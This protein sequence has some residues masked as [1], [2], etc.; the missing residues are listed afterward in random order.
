MAAERLEEGQLALL[1][2]AGHGLGGRIQDIGHLGGPQ[3]AG[4]VGCGLAAGLGCHGA[5]LRLPDSASVPGPIDRLLL[6]RR[7]R[8]PATQTVPGSP[9][10]MPD[11]QDDY[12]D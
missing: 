2:P 3:V 12:Q 4:I 10:W 8:T 7:P 1:G 6:R 5:S 9:C 11:E